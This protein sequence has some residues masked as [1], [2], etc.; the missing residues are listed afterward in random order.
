MSSRVVSHQAADSADDPVDRLLLR[1]IESEPGQR[2][3]VLT[4][5]CDEQPELAAVLRRRA[6]SLLDAGLLDTA[7]PARPL[8]RLG[9][10]RLQRMIGGGG[11]GVVY[12][13]RQ[14][15]PARDVA[16]KLL[17]PEFQPFER[18]RERFRREIAAV[19]RLQHPG[20]VPVYD[21]G[22][23]Q[24]VL[25]LAMEHVAGITLAEL[26]RSLPHRSA[27]RLRGS[28][29]LAVVADHSEPQPA[30]RELCSGSWVEFCLRVVRAI[31][32]AL[33]HAHERGVVHRDVKPSNVML[34]FDGRVMLMDFGLAQASGVTRLTASGAQ[35]GSLPYMAPEQLRGAVTDARTDVYGL[36]VTCYEL[37]SLACPYWEDGPEALRARILEARPVPLAHRNRFVGR[38]AELV[39]QKAMD[40]V[41]G[42]RYASAAA[43][44]DDVDAV[45]QHRSVRA[46]PP[47]LLRRT[48]RWCQRYPTATVAL[49]AVV[50]LAIGG[51]LLVNVSLRS[52]RDE[53]LQQAYSAHV[54]AAAFYLSIHNALGAKQQLQA[55]DPELRGFEWHHLDRVADQSIG[56]LP[57]RRGYFAAVHW[58]GDV[59]VHAGEN[60]G[61]VAVLQPDGT[62]LWHRSLAGMRW[63]DVSSDGRTIAVADGSDRVTR[64]DVT[65][66][67]PLP[68]WAAPDAMPVRWL[69]FLGD[70]GGLALGS[71]AG[72]VVVLDRDGAVRYRADGLPPA[73]RAVTRDG[74]RLLAADLG[75]APFAELWDLERR[76]RIV[77]IGR[78]RAVWSAAFRGDG[79]R[80]AIGC[81]EGVIEVFDRDGA[82]L[83]S[84]VGHAG[85]TVNA[86][87]FASADALWTV[88]NDGTMQRWHP[89][90]GERG[91]TRYG[92][93]AIVLDLDLHDSDGR[94]ATVSPFDGVRIWDGGSAPH[95][96]ILPAVGGGAE[97]LAWSPDDRLL[98]VACSDGAARTW[99][100][101][102]R[103]RLATLPARS[104][105]S[106]CVR[107][108]DFLFGIGFDPEHALV[109]WDLE[110]GGTATALSVAGF[111]D[112]AIAAHPRSG[113][114]ACGHADGSIRLFGAESL[115][116]LARLPG[117]GGPATAL[118]FSPRGDL[119]AVAD[120]AG[121]IVI[122]DADS[123]RRLAATKAR[124]GLR[125]LAFRGGDLW[126]GEGNAVVVRD[127]ATLAERLSLSGHQGWVHDL[128]VAPDGRRVASASHDGTVRVWHA[129]RGDCLLVLTGSGAY[130]YAV[131]F[132]GSGESLAA[133]CADGSVYLWSG[134]ARSMR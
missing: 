110:A 8:D 115:T 131:L 77:E 6:K 55:C 9:P 111:E 101:G 44:A 81:E 122:L 63:L 105:L 35:A 65:T 109:R 89:D 59:L 76:E 19:S 80:L 118:A 13:A 22:E 86:V 127:A 124:D 56:H 84:V 94:I 45:L 71:Q 82:R 75:D 41:P 31:A 78:G 33:Q 36:A 125:A 61:T 10:F 20:I 57:E 34:G 5:L 83:T 119:L 126:C 4:R 23:D 103:R 79:E 132:D 120:L 1:W 67:T 28:D 54:V 134:A 93:E 53:A 12:L 25:Y 37:L 90:N 14:D 106:G 96:T 46:R 129:D 60:D 97:G 99:D 42:R 123:G 68:S 117:P 88:G 30:L 43:F 98:H 121:N 50:L 62:R 69:Q 3:R 52:Q 18:S 91:E 104:R 70:D 73:S 2:D 48:A 64:L 39:C 72:T 92:H 107:T 47:S 85:R 27:E 112:V 32:V 133:G 95:R 15:D 113:V 40:P 17:R 66:G 100:A 49:V 130:V 102:T 16:V 24:N 29:V 74:R 108:G 11:M 116:E 38:A 58:A 128:T 51:P 26:L 114:I 7:A 87:R 21:C